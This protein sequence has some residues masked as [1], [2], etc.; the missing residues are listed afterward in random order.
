MSNAASPA[1]AEAP[2]WQ[3]TACILCS[4]NCGLE[5]QTDGHHILRMRGD[6]E[7]PASQG[8]TCEK[9]ARGLNAYQNARDRLTSPRRRRADGSFEAVSWEIAIAGVARDLARVRDEHGGGSILYFGGGGQGNHLPGGYGSATRAR[10]SARCT[11]RTRSRRRRPASSG[12]TANCGDALI[13]TRR[14]ISST[15]KSRCWSAR[16]RGNPTAS[17]A[18]AWC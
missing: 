4:V 7:H 11:P 6:R 15:Q 3:K 17:R 5:V 18:R 10:R 13:A 12:S 8:Y 14:Q 2:A 1:R 9:P 16:T